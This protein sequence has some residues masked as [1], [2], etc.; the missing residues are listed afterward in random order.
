MFSNFFAY[1]VLKFQVS[2]TITAA[3]VTLRNIFLRSK[4]LSR[5]LFQFFY[6]KYDFLELESLFHAWHI[7]AIS[8]DKTSKIWVR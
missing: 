3:W 2:N 1:N 5:R 8:C 6:P 7:I 4:V